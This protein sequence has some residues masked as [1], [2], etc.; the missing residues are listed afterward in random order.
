MTITLNVYKIGVSVVFVLRGSSCFTDGM[1]LGTI[2]M[3]K[4]ACSRAADRRPRKFRFSNVSIFLSLGILYAV[5]FRFDN[6]PCSRE[7]VFSLVFFVHASPMKV[8]IRFLRLDMRRGDEYDE[9]AGAKDA[10]GLEDGDKAGGFLNGADA[11]LLRPGGKK[12]FEGRKR[13]LWRFFPKACFFP[14]RLRFGQSCPSA[15]WRPAQSAGARAS[16]LICLF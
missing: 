11:L 7:N 15:G 10:G 12:V 9:K 5:S 2:F 14:L 13:F 1:V 8:I 3:G 16:W 4:I 6:V